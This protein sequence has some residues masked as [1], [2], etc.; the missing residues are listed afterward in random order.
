MKAPLLRPSLGAL[1]FLSL[2]RRP[3][4]PT[5]ASSLEIFLLFPGSRNPLSFSHRT[6]SGFPQSSRDPSPLC[7]LAS[8]RF[9][10]LLAAPSPQRAG[11][12]SRS[13]SQSPVPQL[14]LVPPAG[15]LGLP[16]SGRSGARDGVGGMGQRSL[17]GLSRRWGLCHR[18]RRFLLP[19]PLSA[20]PTGCQFELPAQRTDWEN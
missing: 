19:L 14:S 11:W 8:L 17:L 10:S 1:Q 15:P 2:D 12:L 3:S 6:N 7:S 20:F 13:F 18:T 5:H 9:T 4:V 16:P